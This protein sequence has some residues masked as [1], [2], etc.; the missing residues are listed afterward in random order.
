MIQLRPPSATKKSRVLGV[1]Q[2]EQG[3]AAARVGAA[4]LFIA[5]TAARWARATRTRAT[6]AGAGD[7]LGSGSSR[8]VSPDQAVCVLQTL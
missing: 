8:G 5:A 3:E 1:V 7:V 2:L 4:G 6:R